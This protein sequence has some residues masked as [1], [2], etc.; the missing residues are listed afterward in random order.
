[1]VFFLGYQSRE[2]FGNSVC[3][4][5]KSSRRDYMEDQKTGLPS[6]LTFSPSSRL[7]ASKLHIAG[8]RVLAFS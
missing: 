6:E 4:N 5:V 8:A 7:T 3:V 1:M 2:S